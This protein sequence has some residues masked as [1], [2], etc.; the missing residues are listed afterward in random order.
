MSNEFYDCGKKLIGYEYLDISFL[1]PNKNCS[2][3]DIHNDY[4]CSICV[5]DIL[6]GTENVKYTDECEWTIKRGKKRHFNKTFKKDYL[7]EITDDL[8]WVIKKK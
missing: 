7:E 4:L 6:S 2:G 8:E 3:C 5:I 1:K